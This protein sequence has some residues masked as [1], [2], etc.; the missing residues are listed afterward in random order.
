MRRKLVRKW[1]EFSEKK[2][3]KSE[4][5]CRWQEGNIKIKY[6]RRRVR[7]SEVAGKCDC[8][9][10]YDATNDDIGLLMV[11]FMANLVQPDE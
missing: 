1:T 10:N 9:H 8:D 7:A 5:A 6:K 11:E 3:G 4:I 2:V